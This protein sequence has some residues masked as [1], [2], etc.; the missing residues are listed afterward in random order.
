MNVLLT[1][2]VTKWARVW[3]ETTISC[4]TKGSKA[5]KTHLQ[6]ALGAVLAKPFLSVSRFF[7][8]THTHIHVYVYVDIDILLQPATLPQC[9][10]SSTWTCSLQFQPSAV[11][12]ILLLHLTSLSVR[13]LKSGYNILFI[14]FFYIFGDK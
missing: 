12:P 11:K 13:I 6:R 1:S 4:P 14:N 10:S 5:L 3:R 9:Q 8:H 7:C 2:S